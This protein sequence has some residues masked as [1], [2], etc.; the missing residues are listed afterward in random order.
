M[1]L[2]QRE[3]KCLNKGLIISESIVCTSLFVATSNPVR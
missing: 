3:D 1:T 2:W